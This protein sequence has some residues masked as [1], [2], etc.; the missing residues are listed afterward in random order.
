MSTDEI[1]A[2]LPTLTTAERE[3]IFHRLCELKEEDQDGALGTGPTEEEKKLLDE[4]DAELERDGAIGRP[5][6]EVYRDLS[7]RSPS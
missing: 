4:A 6:D 2:Q 5:W 1:L 3:K 7:A